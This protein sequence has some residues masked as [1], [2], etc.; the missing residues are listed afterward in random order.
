MKYVARQ[1]FVAFH[2]RTERWACIVAHRRAGKTVACV[3][4]LVLAALQTKKKNARYAYV[5]PLYVQAK[6]T[7]WA[8]LKDYCAQVEGAS[9]NESEL[10]ADLPNGSRIRL[11][12]AEN[13]DRLRGV[14]LDGVVLDEY[15]DM[16]PKAWSEVL[17]PALADRKGWAVFIGTPKGRNAFF[18]I[19]EHAKANEDWYTLL[20]RASETELLPDSELKAARDVMD[21][22]QYAQEF[23]CSFTAAIQGAYYGKLIDAAE[24][25]KRITSVPYDPKLS[26]F[27]AWDLGIG[28]STVIW[29]AQLAGKE[30][31]LIDYYEASG[32]GLDHYAK[33]LREKP[34]SYQAHIVPHDADVSE[35]G[36]GRTRLEVMKSL[37][38]NAD[39]CR[40]LSV[41]DGINAVRVLLPRCWFDETKCKD[42]L[43][44][45]RQYRREWDE[46]MKTFRA[47]PLHDWSS[48]AADAMRYLAVGLPERISKPAKRPAKP[49]W[50]V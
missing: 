9:F 35:L 24:K 39:V 32:A 30:V 1:Q 15:A 49:E 13:Y 29:F 44:A 33:L 2:E 38:L 36:T 12:G 17:R 31:H 14:Y 34:Y 16:P 21:E 42:G 40:K 27:T 28:D 37:G 3:A 43:E 11:Y 18:E 46:K 20:L 19:H 50:V 25:D 4:D 41:D 22:D 8:Y 5:A 26:V 7:A 45:L 23:E 47:R 6:D 10:R 48:H